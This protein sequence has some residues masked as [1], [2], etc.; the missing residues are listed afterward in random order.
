MEAEF[1]KDSKGIP[2][3]IRRQESGLFRI[4]SR[5]EFN[6]GTVEDCP[7]YRHTVSGKTVFNCKQSGKHVDYFIKSKSF[8]FCTLA[9]CIL[10]S[11]FT[12][13]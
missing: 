2:L 10:V 4:G 8:F 3:Y 7:M 13:F 9:S 6:D 11:I 1:K 5:R 12:I